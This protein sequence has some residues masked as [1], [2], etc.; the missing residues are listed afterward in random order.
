MNPT[1]V[2]QSNGTIPRILLGYIDKL[3]QHHETTPLL[4]YV[5]TP[6]PYS[7]PVY[8]RSTQYTKPPDISNPLSPKRKQR[9]QSIVGS[10]LYYARAIDG[11]LLPALN[12]I[13]AHQ[14]NPTEATDT[15]VNHLLA[16]VKFNKTLLSDSMQATCVYM[17]IAT[18][19]ILSCPVLE[20]ELPVII[21]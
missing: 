3:L 15:K 12:K 9:L 16:F 7:Q 10:L 8:G 2:S 14:A 19:L 21:T 20:A 18:P 5:S 4:K 6:H 11:S 13:S 1:A 17:S